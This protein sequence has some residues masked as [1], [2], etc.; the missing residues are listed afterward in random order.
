MT[1]KTDTHKEPEEKTPE[2]ERME[3]LAKLTPEQVL[4]KARKKGFVGGRERK[5]E[6]DLAQL[7]LL[8]EIKNELIRK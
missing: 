7:Q 8:I 3:E 1:K 4:E 2:Q 5:E 6:V